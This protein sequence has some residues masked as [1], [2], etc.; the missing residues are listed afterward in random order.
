VRRRARHDPHHLRGEPPE[1]G[2]RLP[3]VDVDE[4]LELPLAGEVRNLGLEIRGRVPV[5][6]FGTYGSGSGIF[7]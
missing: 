1:V 7:D 2:A 5:S 6:P 4:L 3:V